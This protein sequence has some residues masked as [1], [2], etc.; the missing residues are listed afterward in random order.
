[1][2]EPKNRSKSL[3]VLGKVMSF[4]TVPEGTDMNDVI[5]EMEK[6][7][8]E[9][10]KTS[11]SGKVID[12][13]MKV[14]SLLKVSPPDLSFHLNMKVKDDTTFSELKELIANY[15]DSKR[16]WSSSSSTNAALPQQPAPMD[17]DAITVKGGERVKGKDKKGGNAGKS[18][19]NPNETCNN[20]GKTGHR[21]AQ[22]WAVGGGAHVQG[23]V[24]KGGKD[25]EKGK[26]P[27]LKRRRS[28]RGNG[29]KCSLNKRAKIEMKA[30]KAE[31][32]SAFSPILP[33]Q[34]RR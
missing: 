20:C 14:A 30:L 16:T 19:I 27:M 28:G 8:D 24:G 3:V 21:K 10:Q 32:L 13:E 31:T 17:V 4:D 26:P 7:F 34:G 18:G 25:K 15:E 23:K 6:V 11:R 5:R 12:D 29:G 33:R 22:C 9:Y 2:L 1:M